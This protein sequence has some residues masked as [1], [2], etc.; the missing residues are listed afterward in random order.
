MVAPDLGILFAG[1]GGIDVNPPA[2]VVAY[3]ILGNQ[4]VDR[5]S[6]AGVDI[7]PLCALIN[8]IAPDLQVHI[9]GTGITIDTRAAGID[10]I[11]G[12]LER[13]GLGSSAG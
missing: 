4:A 9:T 5:I 11:A 10:C 3:G 2:A 12:Y 13:S 1:T 8:F 7:N 6:A